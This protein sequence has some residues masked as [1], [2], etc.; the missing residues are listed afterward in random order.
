MSAIDSTYVLMSV[1]CGACAVFPC[2]CV[3][4][5]R[6]QLGDLCHIGLSEVQV[7]RFTQL[8]L[9][10]AAH[11]QPTTIAAGMDE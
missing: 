5:F 4:V 9:M 6:V 10:P 2:L 3:C 7:A 1:V 11:A 8:N